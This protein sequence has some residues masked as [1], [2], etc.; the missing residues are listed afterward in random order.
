[1]GY[2][3]PFLSPFVRPKNKINRFKLSCHILERRK[4]PGWNQIITNFITLYIS[5]SFGF[6]HFFTAF[7]KCPAFDIDVLDDICIF[8]SNSFIRRQNVELSF[9]NSGRLICLGAETA[10]PSSGYFPKVDLLLLY[11]YINI[12]FIAENSNSNV[13]LKKKNRNWLKF[14]FFLKVLNEIE[15]YVV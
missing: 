3:C 2:L 10:T 11:L 9:K 14:W 13:R 6:T 7:R 5:R 8:A 4:G 12:S 15:I 1:M